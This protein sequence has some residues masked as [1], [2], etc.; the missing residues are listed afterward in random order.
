MLITYTL[1]QR[2]VHCN[3]FL[4]QIRL[5]AGFFLP[6]DLSRGALLIE[7]FFFQ[8]NYFVGFGQISVCGLINWNRCDFVRLSLDNHL[9]SLGMFKVCPLA[10]A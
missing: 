6:F 3:N 2:D 10:I 8:R 5:R 7:T 9:Q 1:L 4:P